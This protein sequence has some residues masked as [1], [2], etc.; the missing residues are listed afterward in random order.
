MSYLPSGI[1][2]GAFATALKIPVVITI[3]LSLFVYSGAVQSA[4][5]GFWV[6]GLEPFS[7]ILTSFLLNLRHTFY[8]PHIESERNDIKLKNVLT[9]GPLLTDEVYAL[10]V[11]PLFPDKKHIFFLAIF[12]Y[13]NW[14]SA[15]ALGAFVAGIAPPRVLDILLIALP[16]LF[17]GLL[18]PRVRSSYAVVTAM[19]A[20]IIAISGRL[21]H[22]PAFFIII[23]I[24]GGVIIGYAWKK[25]EEGH[26]L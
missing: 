26:R 13:A 5:L 22:L 12:A 21:L 14:A 19:S 3:A 16:T 7:M 18:V 15:T 4:F 10:S 17:L 24:L 8:G 9:I 25:F 23:P 1:A 11:S 2:F 6:T 20:G